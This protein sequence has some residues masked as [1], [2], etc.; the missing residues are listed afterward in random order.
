MTN[1]NPIPLL[2]TIALIEGV[3]FLLLLFVAMPLK[4]FAGMPMAVKVVGWA[5]GVLFVAL[6]VALVR[7]MIVARWPM[8]RGAMVFV[9]ALLP[10]GPFVIDRRMMGYEE[11]LRR[12]GRAGE[13]QS[14]SSPATQTPA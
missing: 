6:C 13:E 3:S 11:E 12:S 2:R 10:F 1:R 8:G 7:V 4:Y 14:G 5:H 9:A